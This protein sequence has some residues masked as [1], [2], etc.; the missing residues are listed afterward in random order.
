MLPAKLG[1][2]MGSNYLR[3]WQYWVSTICDILPNFMYRTKTCNTCM[4]KPV[5]MWSFL[6]ASFENEGR[7]VTG[8]KVGHRHSIQSLVTEW[9]EGREGGR[10]VEDGEKGVR[11]RRAKMEGKEGGRK[12]DWRAENSCNLI[13]LMLIIL[14]MCEFSP[15]VFVQ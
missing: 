5:L 14:G 10:E 4:L 8:R 15:S 1:N 9:R 3:Q 2:I 12:E 6:M 7:L 13:L 11:W